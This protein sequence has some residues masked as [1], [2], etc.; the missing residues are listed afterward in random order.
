MLAGALRH[1]GGEAVL[2][3]FDVYAIYVPDLDRAVHFYERVLGATFKPE[4][5]TENEAPG[6]VHGLPITLVTSPHK[7]AVLWYEVDDIEAAREE[8]KSKATI[9]LDLHDIPPGRA[10]RFADPF[11]NVYGV[12]Q[13]RAAG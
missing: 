7:H 10:L 5:R 11:G 12:Y 3:A 1:W 8:L 13:R 9:V 6:N 2:K 4:L